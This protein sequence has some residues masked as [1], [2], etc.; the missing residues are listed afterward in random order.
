MNQSN[1]IV[2]V[3]AG[4]TAVGKT[5]VAIEVAKHFGTEIISADSRQCYKELNIGVARPGSEELASVTHHFIASHSVHDNITAAY[6]EKF[7]LQKAEELLQVKDVLVVTGG[8]GLYIKAFMEGLDTIPE[9]PDTVRKQVV[10]NYELHGIKWLQEEI[11]KKD[12]AFYTHGEIQNTHRLLRA[13]EVIEATGQSLLTYQKRNVATRPFRMIPFA[14]DVPRPELY[15]R[16]N[17]RVALMM[18]NGLQDEVKSL[19]PLQHLNALQTVGYKELFSFFKNDIS[20]ERAVE[21]IKQNTRHYAKRQVTWFNNQGNFHF[22]PP[23]ADYILDHLKIEMN[24]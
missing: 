8:T 10:A 9:I 22:V 23:K 24:K 18:E 16:I 17:Q 6:F 11:R 3:I 15:N 20:L 5:A 7:A 19:I 4:P 14:L 21:L 1:K 2:I 13:L 12:P